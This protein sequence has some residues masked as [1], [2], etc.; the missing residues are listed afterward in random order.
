MYEGI[1]SEAGAKG[2]ITS[3]SYSSNW[4]NTCYHGNHLLI[5]KHSFHGNI[6]YWSMFCV[7]SQHAQ[8]PVPLWATLSDWKVAVH[9]TMQD[10]SVS[11]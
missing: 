7:S 9:H 2:N 6:I 5:G 10:S 4:V 3:T 8:C 1:F 11:M